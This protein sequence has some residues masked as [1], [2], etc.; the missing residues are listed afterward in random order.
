MT[1]SSTSSL[2]G[3]EQEAIKTRC[4]AQVKNDVQSMTQL[5][6]NIP[7]RRCSI[8]NAQEK[9]YAGGNFPLVWRMR[10]FDR[11]MPHC[12]ICCVLTRARRQEAVRLGKKPTTYNNQ[13]LDSFR[14]FPTNGGSGHSGTQCYWKSHSIDIVSGGEPCLV[15]YLAARMNMRCCSSFRL[16]HPQ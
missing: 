7:Y 14:R 10:S 2:A 8:G 9:K 12:N 1:S 16:P 6:T 3:H 4:T 11:R 15:R 5:T 13:G